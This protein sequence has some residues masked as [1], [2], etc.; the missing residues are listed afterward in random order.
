METITDADVF[1]TNLKPEVEEVSKN[2]ESLTATLLA[3]ISD[4]SKVGEYQAYYYWEHCGQFWKED[5]EA[6]EW[7]RKTAGQATKPRRATG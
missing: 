2:M 7:L 4:K 6:L 3:F 5:A 1:G